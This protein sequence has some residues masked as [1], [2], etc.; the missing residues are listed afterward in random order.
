MIKRILCHKVFHLRG[1]YS[2]APIS[3]FFFYQRNICYRQFA[4]VHRIIHCD[5]DVSRCFIWNTVEAM[6]LERN[7]MRTMENTWMTAL[8]RVEG[9]WQTIGNFPIC[10]G[11]P[12]NLKKCRFSKSI[13]GYHIVLFIISA[14]IFI[15]AILEVEFLSRMDYIVMTI[16][17]IIRS[18]SALVCYFLN[19]S[20]WIFYHKDFIDAMEFLASQNLILQQLGCRMDYSLCFKM[21]RTYVYG[22][23]TTVAVLLIYDCYTSMSTWASESPLM[24]CQ[25]IFFTIPS[26][27]Q[28]ITPTIFGSLVII[29]GVHFREVN[30]KL[31]AIRDRANSSP[32]KVIELSN[33]CAEGVRL[34]AKIHYNLCKIGKFLNW[35]FNGFFVV[36]VAT[37]FII[38]S[39]SLYFIFYEVVKPEETNYLSIGSYISWQIT[40]AAPMIATVVICNWTSNQAEHTGKLIHEIHIESTESKLYQIIR[41]LSLQLHHQKVEFSGAG[42]FPIN[43]SLLQTM[44]GNMTTSLVILIQFQPSLN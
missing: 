18:L 37:A 8:A 9:I 5:K 27:I 40:T 38:L 28:V 19:S 41:S 34:I 30:T 11:G 43:S 6:R 7:S 2:N 10:F 32:P 16:T 25:W 36:I 39:S 24:V 44:I 4:N 15:S 35:M 3:L 13:M 33:D 17:M 1:Y 23:L 14:G 12:D 42:L 29:L 31:M 22:T 20:I 21:V 26:V